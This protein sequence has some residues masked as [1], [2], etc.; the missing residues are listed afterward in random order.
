MNDNKLLLVTTA[1]DLRYRL[2]LF[3]SYRKN[4]VKEKLKFNLKNLFLSRLIKNVILL[5][6]HQT[7]QNHNP[8]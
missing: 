1:I 4:F 8:M 5:C 7:K 6:S 2:S 3:P